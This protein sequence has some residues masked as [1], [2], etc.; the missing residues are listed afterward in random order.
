MTE[1]IAVVIPPDENVRRTPGG[2]WACDCGAPCARCGE[3]ADGWVDDCGHFYGNSAV[4]LGP[5]ERDKWDGLVLCRECWEWT[6]S[7]TGER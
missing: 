3:P 5:N 7:R 1:L 2:G 4:W 6:G